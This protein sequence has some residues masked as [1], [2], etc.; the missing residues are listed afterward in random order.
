MAKILPQGTQL[1]CLAPKADATGFDLIKIPCVVSV[2]VGEDARDEHE[3]TCLEETESHTFMPGLNTP[4]TTSF[5][6]RI[7]PAS[8]AHVRLNQLSDTNTRL[9]W[10]LGW[11]DGVDV[12]PAEMVANSGEFTLPSQRT[13]NTFVGHVA[14]FNFSGFELAGEPLQATINIKRSTKVRWVVKTGTGG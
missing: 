1:Y 14:G 9:H 10:A 8:T 7:D 3:D 13:W 11:S 5:S 2:D 6:V 4:G 12:D